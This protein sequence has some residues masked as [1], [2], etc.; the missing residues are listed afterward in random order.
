MISTLQFDQVKTNYR[1]DMNLC[2][3]SDDE[4]SPKLYTVKSKSKKKRSKKGSEV[5]THFGNQQN[6]VL[7]RSPILLP[8]LRSLQI[9][10]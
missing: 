7:F 8:S 9:L 1:A 3:S 5:R 2:E 6:L 10:C 4:D